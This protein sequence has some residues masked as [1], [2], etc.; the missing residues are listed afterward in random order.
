[1]VYVLLRKVDS[2]ILDRNMKKNC[3]I[4]RGEKYTLLQTIMEGKVHGRRSVG[5][6]K[7]S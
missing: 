3:H 4:L 2:I 7:K 6:K 1:M 5:I